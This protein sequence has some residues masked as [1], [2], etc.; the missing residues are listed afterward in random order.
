[1]LKSRFLRDPNI[2]YRTLMI[3][4][5]Q[6]LTKNPKNQHYTISLKQKRRRPKSTSTFRFGR[7][8]R[9]RTQIDGFGDRCSTI[10]LYPCGAENEIRTRDPLLG[11]EVLYR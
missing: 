9:T 8:T 11:K 2:Y 3:S 4:R 5:P 7:G 6:C 10:E 1:M